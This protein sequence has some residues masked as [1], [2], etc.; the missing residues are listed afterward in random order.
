MLCV[1]V[2]SKNGV[3][4]VS[5]DN[6]TRATA[7]TNNSR[8]VTRCGSPNQSTSVSARH[9]DFYYF[10]FLSFLTIL[11]PISYKI[12]YSERQLD[13]DYH[14]NYISIYRIKIISKNDH[15]VPQK[16]HF[17]CWFCKIYFD[18]KYIYFEKEK[19]IFSK[20]TMCT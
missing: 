5:R 2:C 16:H 17:F 10:Y 4:V 18:M 6:M 15:L 9:S 12:V 3:G 19:Y 20:P 1:S 14:H 8:A 13:E 11:P 7:V